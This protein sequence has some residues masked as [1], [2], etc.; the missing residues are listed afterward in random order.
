MQEAMQPRI[1]P[2]PRILIYD[3]HTSTA[4]V[5]KRTAEDIFG[6]VDLEGIIIDTT[7]NAQ[8]AK[9]LL[10]QEYYD[11]VIAGC[12]KDTCA[13][14]TSAG[15]KVL[16][17]MSAASQV[18]ILSTDL[19]FT[20]AKLRKLDVPQQK[21]NLI[22]SGSK[23]RHCWETLRHVNE[24]MFNH[25]NVIEIPPSYDLLKKALATTLK[26]SLD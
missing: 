18:I 16:E 24:P 25:F 14:E 5:V 10:K 21:I 4:E 7:T 1:L 26:L 13:V 9:E 6:N 12:Y 17:G 23:P 8:A 2:A 15:M 20:Y 19:E 3:S 22:Y 11:L